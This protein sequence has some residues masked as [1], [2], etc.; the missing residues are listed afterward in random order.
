MKGRT[1]ERREIWR[2]RCLEMR[3]AKEGPE[4]KGG[5]KS[6]GERRKYFDYFESRLCGFPAAA[7]PDNRL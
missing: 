3:G 2:Q 1:A 4:K 5:R 6:R 7:Q